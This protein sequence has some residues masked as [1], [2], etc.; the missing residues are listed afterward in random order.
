MPKAYVL[1]DGSRLYLNDNSTARVRMTP[2]VR[3]V[4]LD[5]GELLVKVAH[6]VKR[7][8]RVSADKVVLR[9]IGTAFAVRRDL[10]GGVEVAVEEGTVTV[11]SAAASF[12]DGLSPNGMIVT[13]GQAALISDRVV[14]IANR[15]AAEVENRLSWVHGKLYLNGTLL[16]AIEKFNEH[17][18]VKL[19]IEDDSLSNLDVNGVYGTH[20]VR[21]FADSLRARGIRYEV[22]PAG[23]SKDTII[24]L[25]SRK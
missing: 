6:D 2:V 25:M 20:A 4:I 14:S 24:A 18:E 1:S 21:E 7:D 10:D 17:N 16:Q 23:G 13:A 11:K 12:A 3:E 9:A 19:V 15:E 5:R 8:F 22:R